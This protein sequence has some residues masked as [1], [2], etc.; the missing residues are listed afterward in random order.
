MQTSPDSPE[1]TDG[2]EELT[3]EENDADE[4]QG[5]IIARQVQYI[6]TCCL[7][8]RNILQS[9]IELS[10]LMRYAMTIDDDDDDYPMPD[11]TSDEEEYGDCPAPC[12][13][14]GGETVTEIADLL[15][16]TVYCTSNSLYIFVAAI[17]LGS[18]I[19]RLRKPCTRA[20]L[21]NVRTM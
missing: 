16:S 21:P 7:R 20:C 11:L 9:R 3:D 4:D 10:R 6:V 1:L 15:Y 19:R 17:T 14:K 8:E 12:K 13:R 2:Q 5:D 18:V